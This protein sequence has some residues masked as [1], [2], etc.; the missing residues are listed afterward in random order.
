MNTE[1]IKTSKELFE[2]L[3]AAKSDRA[4]SLIAHAAVATNSYERV[5]TDLLGTLEY[6]RRQIER[7]QRDLTDSD[8]MP[9]SLGI[10]QNNGVEADRL[11]GELARTREAAAD[12][13]KLL[14]TLG[15]E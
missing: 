5:R 8:S 10:L 4:R 14:T 2:L 9:N 13:Q 1:T 12:A 11:C 7:A 6:C 15:I 3:T